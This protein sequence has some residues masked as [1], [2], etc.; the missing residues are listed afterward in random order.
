LSRQPNSGKLAI[1]NA[2]QLKAL[3]GARYDLLSKRGL[4]AGVELQAADGGDVDAAYQALVSEL[5]D[6][7]ALEVEHQKRMA[8][9][10]LGA[11]IVHEV[12]N[13]VTSIRGFA[14]IARRKSGE[15]SE[16]RELLE[17]ITRESQRCVDSLSGFLGFA[18]QSYSATTVVD[19]VDVLRR[20]EALVRHQLQ[21]S[22]IQ[23]AVDAVDGPLNARGDRS[24]LVQVLVNL[25]LNAQQ[26]ML[27]GGRV[28]IVANRNDDDSIEIS[29][30]DS[31]PGVPEELRQRIFEPFF[32]TKSDRGGTGLG[33]SI[34]ARIVA[35]VGGS[36]DVL[37]AP[38][39]G[40][41]FVVRLQQAAAESC[42]G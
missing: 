38:N 16:V 3:F 29:V 34:S 8:L 21:V 18:R 13:M 1:T 40:A 15:G 41:R 4:T 7:E 2:E 19:V 22:E 42:D 35:G 39:G 28:E 37:E 30:S 5:R 31:G 20:T 27:Q 24:G 32:T 10:Q 25:V 26:A 11:G 33:L 6:I 23:L 36:L 17:T 12:R 9:G 14:Q